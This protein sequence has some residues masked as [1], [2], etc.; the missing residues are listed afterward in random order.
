MRVWL[1]WLIFVGVVVVIAFL[2]VGVCIYY[3]SD[4]EIRL[5]IGKLRLSFSE[6]EKKQ[7]KEK[8]SASPNSGKKA[9]RNIKHWLHVALENRTE[10]INLFLRVLSTPVLDVLRIDISVG[11]KEP[12]QCALN[13]GRICALVGVFLAPVESAFVIKK[14]SVNIQCTFEEAEIEF[15]AEAAMT[16]RVY[17]I[18]ALVLAMLKL[19]FGLYHQV[20]SNMKVV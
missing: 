9:K 6:K 18:V 7:A 1:P 13:Y 12:D 4:L 14:R 20:K 16:L 19:G 11:G 17:E 8:T 5:L 10:I 2:K 15:K 3:S